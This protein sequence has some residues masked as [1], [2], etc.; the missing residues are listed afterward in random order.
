MFIAGDHLLVFGE[1]LRVDHFADVMI[2]RPH[3]YQKRM[4][5]DGISRRFRQI[6]DD[7][8]VVIRAWRLHHHALH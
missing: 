5:V 8:T 6:A 7:Q 1:I 3:P 2:I 4:G